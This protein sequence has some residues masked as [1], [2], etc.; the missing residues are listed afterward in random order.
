MIGV[1]FNG[2][3]GN[4]LFQFAFFC[5]LRSRAPGKIMF[6]VNPHHSRIGQ[7]FDL[8]MYHNL[9]IS[10]KIYSVFA[11]TMGH[12]L[13]LKR[14]Y[15]QNIQ[16]PRHVDPVNGTL[17]TGFFQTDFYYEHTPARFKPTFKIK[18]KYTDQFDTLFGESFRNNRTIVVHIRRTDYLTYLKRDISLPITYFKAQLDSIENLDTYLVY[19][20]SDDIDYVKKFFGEKPNFIFSYN[21]EII[22]FQIILNAD[23]KIISNSSFSWWAAYLSDK[24]TKIIAPKNWMGFRIGKEHPKKVMTKRF[25]WRDVIDTAQQD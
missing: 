18:K 21:N 15:I 4:Q 16:V 3:L 7:Y 13:P 8:G 14:N 5:Y 17:Y 24:T 6:F 2:R 11:R 12:V 10:S 22:D 20:V 25:I 23:I 1:K 9:T 19:F